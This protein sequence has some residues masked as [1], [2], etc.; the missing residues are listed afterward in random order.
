M[1]PIERNTLLLRL[2]PAIVMP[3][4]KIKEIREGPV[5]TKSSLTQSLMQDCR[6]VN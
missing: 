4:M 5:E 6:K 2:M 1:R 3:F